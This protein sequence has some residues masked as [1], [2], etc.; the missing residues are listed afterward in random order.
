MVGTITESLISDIGRCVNRIASDPLSV[1]LV[2]LSAFLIYSDHYTPDD[3][4][5]H[6]LVEKIRETE[7]VAF[8]GD[9]IEQNK[10]RFLGI[11]A[12]VPA[13]TSSPQRTR[14]VLAMVA[15]L[16]VYCVPEGSSFEYVAQSLLLM[17][18]MCAHNVSTKL[19]V[20]TTF[21]I[22]YSLGYINIPGLFPS[23]PSSNSTAPLSTPTS[24]PKPARI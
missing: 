18:F 8:I 21:G 20:I 1:L 24:A 9:W 16:W 10:N 5:V 14:P 22:V 17:L 2:F 6:K 11:A 4:L 3:S 15:F 13:L 7:K 23:K 12:F 19:A